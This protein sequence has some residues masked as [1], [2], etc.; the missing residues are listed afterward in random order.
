MK[1]IT[2]KENTLPEQAMLFFPKKDEGHREYPYKVDA[3]KVDEI[4]L[5]LEETIKKVDAHEFPATPGFVSHVVA[6]CCTNP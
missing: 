2:L 6:R 4:I 5:Q 3:G 1:G